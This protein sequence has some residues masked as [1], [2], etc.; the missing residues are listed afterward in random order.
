[1]IRYRFYP[2]LL[3][4]YQNYLDAESIWEKYWGGSD[5][6]S[7]SLD[8]YIDK[9][10]AELIEKINR[11]PH[12]P[13]EAADKGTCFNEIV[14][15]INSNGNP[16]NDS[17]KLQSCDTHI[18]ARTDNFVFL[19]DIATCKDAAAYFKDSIPQHFCKAVLPTRYGDVELYGYAD[20]IRGD[21]VYD[22][23]TTSGQ[24]EYGKFLKSWQWRT[25]PYCLIQSGEMREVSEFEYTVF[26]LNKKEPLTAKMYCEAYPYIHE[27]AK[28]DLRKVCESFIEFLDIHR[29]QITD[30]KI[31]NL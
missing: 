29:D 13:I 28:E 20:E 26:V 7:I 3:D 12:E 15:R 22:I 21:K 4:S 1:M 30:K 25:Y 10:E 11:V 31:F 5:E 16:V 9:T 19:F 18:E 2:S 27:K 6:P 23:K 24:Y 14:D 8:E 17:V